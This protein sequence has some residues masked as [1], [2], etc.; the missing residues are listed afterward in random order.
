MESNKV[1]FVAHLI[2]SNDWKI[3]FSENL[4]MIV[5][6][7]MDKNKLKNMG[8][9]MFKFISSKFIKILQLRLCL[10]NNLRG[11][12]LISRSTLAERSDV[13]NTGQMPPAAPPAPPM[14]HAT[15]KVVS[16]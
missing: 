1:F 6:T 13:P 14:R 15:H 4:P 10:V 9:L 16:G 2:S 7:A 8:F 5:P 12:L 3:Y 11:K